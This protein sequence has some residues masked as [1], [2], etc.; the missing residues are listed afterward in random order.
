MNDSSSN[1]ESV[2][3]RILTDKPVR[4]TPY[5]VKG[6]F[7]K[8]YPNEPIVSMINGKNREKY[9]IYN[10]FT[11]IFIKVQKLC[12]TLVKIFLKKK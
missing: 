2:V 9:F 10:S 3:V 11:V 4:K 6:V 12:L 5:Q 8:Q 7:M 1:I